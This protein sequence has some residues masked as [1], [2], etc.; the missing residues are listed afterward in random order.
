MALKSRSLSGK[1]KCVGFDA[2]DNLI[3]DL[4]DGTIEALVVQDPFKMGFEAVKTLVDKLNG[5]TPPKQIDLPG[6]CCHQSRSRQT[7][8]S[9]AA[10]S[11]C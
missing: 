2:S 6:A 3:D 4:K 7:R 1:V 9:R 5:I 8:D 10:V 11:R